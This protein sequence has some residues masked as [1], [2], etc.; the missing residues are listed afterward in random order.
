VS[1]LS[2]W[3]GKVALVTGA[4][5]GIGRETAIMLA[6]AGL[7][8]A[9]CARREGLLQEVAN[10]SAGDVLPLAVDLQDTQA[11]LGMFETI[12][13]H[14]GGVD[15]LINNAGIGFN[16]PLVSGNTEHWRA[17]L[18][19]NVLALCVCTREGISDMR[20]RGDNGHVFHVSS[21]AGHRVP[22]G[23]GVYSASKY[24]VR[25]LTEGL[26]QELRHL[27]SHIRVTAISPGFVETGFH[28]HYHQSAEMA[29]QTYG[30][31]KVLES[32]DVASAIVY[33]LSCP[34]H[35]AIHDILI[36]PTTQPN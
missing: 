4:S 18:D 15:V 6:N 10:Q 24:A 29:Q 19:L 28:E 34:A 3:Q 21:M 14:W 23:S 8:V 31:F 26:R 33:A 1:D 9:I 25:A 27:D 22:S 20:R 2:A 35:M 13:D 16:E 12:R 30:R 32:K 36:R 17:M 5:G 11:I 7:K